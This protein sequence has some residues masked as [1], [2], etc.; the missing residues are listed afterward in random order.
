MAATLL[1]KP[2]PSLSRDP[3]PDAGIFVGTIVVMHAQARG[4]AEF[5]IAWL[6]G[7]W[8]ASR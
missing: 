3:W 8:S 5:W 6:L 7:D 1:F 4:L 2:Y